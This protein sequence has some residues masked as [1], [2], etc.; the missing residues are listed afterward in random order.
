MAYLSATAFR[1]EPGK[2]NNSNVIVIVITVM[3]C[4]VPHSPVTGDYGHQ[5]ALYPKQQKGLITTI[6]HFVWREA[7]ILLLKLVKP[8]IN[9]NVNIS[10]TVTMIKEVY[11]NEGRGQKLR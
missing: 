2:S 9:Q 8:S 7:D 3:Y 1:V 10:D 6:L 11:A 4:W 5:A